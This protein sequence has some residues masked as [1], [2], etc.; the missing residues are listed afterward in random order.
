VS[1]CQRGRPNGATGVL[2]S[3]GGPGGTGRVGSG[4]TRGWT[5]EETD[6]SRGTRG[7]DLGD[8]NM[9]RGGSEG[10]CRSWGS[11]GGSI[12]LGRVGRAAAGGTNKGPVSGGDHAGGGVLTR[13]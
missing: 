4:R 6:R 9:T 3:L 11:A 10:G 5:G 13:N 1:A 8:A 7:G 12:T 2:S